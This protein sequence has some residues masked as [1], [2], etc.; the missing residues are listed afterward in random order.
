MSG[1]RP[2]VCLVMVPSIKILSMMYVY[3][4]TLSREDALHI[5]NDV[6]LN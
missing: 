5:T 6:C 2:I 3:Y 4:V 1:D